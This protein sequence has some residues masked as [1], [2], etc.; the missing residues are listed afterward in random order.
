[1]QCEPV[2]RMVG[3]Q[4]YQYDRNFLRCGRD[5]LD[6][7]CKMRRAG[8]DG[9]CPRRRV[10]ELLHFTHGSALNTIAQLGSTFM[11]RQHLAKFKFPIALGGSNQVGF[12]AKKKDAIR[13]YCVP[14]YRHSGDNHESC[15]IDYSYLYHIYR[16]LGQRRRQYESLSTS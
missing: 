10:D 7:A 4:S 5:L 9:A 14:K 15:T 16:V 8:L 2:D 3:G 13:T 6:A 1:M 11:V 12:G